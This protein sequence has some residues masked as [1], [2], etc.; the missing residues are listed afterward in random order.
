MTHRKWY[1][2]RPFYGASLVALVA[3]AIPVSQ[4]LASASSSTAKV[5]IEH[6]TGGGCGDVA[7]KKVIGAATFQRSKS[8]NVTITWKVHGA[9]PTGSY[10]LSLFANSP[11]DC[12]FIT[13]IGDIK[14]D[15]SGQGTRTVTVSNMN[16]IT[17]FFVSAFNATSGDYDVSLIAHV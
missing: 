8:G 16:G 9:D 6:N 3:L 1:R 15:A 10:A 13:P 12:Q 2:G 4:T 14:I 7:N 11:N 17:D 5:P